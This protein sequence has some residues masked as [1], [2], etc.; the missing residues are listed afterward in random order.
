MYHLQYTLYND[1]CYYYESVTLNV[2]LKAPDAMKQYYMSLTPTSNGSLVGVANGG[3]YVVS[4][5]KYNTWITL[6]ISAKD[7][8]EFVKGKTSALLFGTY[9]NGDHPVFDREIYVGDITFNELPAN[10]NPK[11]D[12]EGSD[13]EW[14]N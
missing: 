11:Y 9:V 13:I 3:Q 10:E 2:A 12:N 7:F 1:F 4:G 8:V 14:N 5:D 6:T